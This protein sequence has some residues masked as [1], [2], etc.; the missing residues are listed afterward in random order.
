MK[1]VA[2]LLGS[3]LCLTLPAWADDPVSPRMP[4]PDERSASELEQGL[5][6]LNRLMGHAQEYLAEHFDLSGGL[7]PEQGD[8]RHGH[9]RFKFFPKGRSQSSEAVEADTNF[10]LK[11]GQFS[12]HFRFREPNP[13]SALPPGIL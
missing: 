7:Q 2:M 13:A 9:L 10:E 3:I 5:A 8:D 6:L 1:I 12:F 4:P 11:D